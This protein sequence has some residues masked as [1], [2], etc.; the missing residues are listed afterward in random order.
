MK[1]V[2]SARILGIVMGRSGELHASYVQLL[3][4][5]RRQLIWIQLCKVK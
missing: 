5:L 1:F 2:S 3:D 4:N